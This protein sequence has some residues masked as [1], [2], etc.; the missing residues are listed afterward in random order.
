MVDRASGVG[1]RL[2]VIIFVLIAVLGLRTVRFKLH[3]CLMRI[4]EILLYSS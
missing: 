4:V 2:F 3:P 1:A